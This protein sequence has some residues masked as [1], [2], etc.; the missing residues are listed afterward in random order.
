MTRHLVAAFYHFADLAD[1]ETLQG[2]LLETC[3]RQGIL[4]MIL[5]AHEGINGTVSGSEIGVRSLLAELRS[6]PRLA[7]LEHKEAWSN[8]PPFRVM[9]VRLKQEIVSMGVD[10]IAPPKQAGQ[11]VSPE[12][13]NALIRDPDVV[14]IDT[15]NDY[16]TDIGT[17]R[18]ATFPMTRTFRQ[19]PD[20]LDAQEALNKDTKIAMF[21]TG[22]IRCEKSTSL[23]RNKGF[24]NVYHLRGGI[25]NYLEK[26]PKEESLW[27]GECF[28]FDQRVAVDHDLQPSEK[29][30]CHACGWTVS[31]DMREHPDYVYGVSCN[32]C[33]DQTTADQKARFAERAK[34]IALAEARG[35]EHLGADLPPPRPSKKRAPI[36]EGLPILYSFRRCP[37]A[38]RARLAISVSHQHCTLREVVL[39]DK[40]PSLLE[41]SPKGTVPVL[42][43]PDQRVIDESLDIMRWALEHADPENWLIPDNGALEDALALIKTNDTEFKQHLD[44]YK[45][46]N[47]YE[48]VDPVAH[49]TEAE[50]FLAQLD[51]RLAHTAHLFGARPCLA[52]MAIMPFVRQFANTDREWFGQSRYAHLRA[53]L[54]GHL[55]SERFISVMNK[56]KQWHSDMPG[57]RFP[58]SPA[59]HQLET[60]GTL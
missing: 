6:D 56:Y 27:D 18:G 58:V 35:Q 28:V 17:F 42:V 60:Q 45:Y 24:Q 19:F 37:Y 48:D 10:G 21:C 33:V 49:R 1:F 54:E 44:R 41:Y 53:W 11:Y 30:I 40:P 47:R 7:N 20:W 51:R 22:G 12:D 9:K 23:L 2:P 16:E 32:R 25:L 36:P 5:L 14:L 31:A 13:W 29:V 39:R 4:G 3:E 57:E 59:P 34:Q 43:L 15:R 26:V 50:T 55:T 52:D 46:A 8:D 38:I